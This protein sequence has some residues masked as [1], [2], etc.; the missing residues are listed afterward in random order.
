MPLPKINFESK[1]T[2]LRSFDEIADKIGKEIQ[3]QINDAYY[4]LID[5]EFY[6]YAEKFPDPHTYKNDLQLQFGKFYLHASGVDITLGDGKNYCGLL[7]RGIV[8][9]SVD[10]GPEK[11]FVHKATTGSQNCATEIFSN[12]HS[13]E[14]NPNNTIRLIDIDGHNQDSCFYPAKKVLNTKR[15]GLTPKSDDLK[16]FYLDLPLR[17]ITILQKCPSNKLKIP[18]IDTIVGEKLKAG[19]L[20][21][22]EAFD[23][24]GYNKKI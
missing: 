12:L 7:I 9:L 13:L 8:E 3:L 11:G 24:L 23:I 15:V 19:E 20:T 21:S 18:G 17:Y 2:I 4:R 16:S 10:A 14:S 5:F 6:A 1:E 22:E